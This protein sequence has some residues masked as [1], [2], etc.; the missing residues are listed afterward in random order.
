MNKRLVWNFE[1]STESPLQLPRANCI[2][3][4]KTHWESR[5]FWPDNERIVLRGLNDTHRE[6]S[7]YQVKHREDCYFLLPTTDYNIKIRHEQLSYKPVLMKKPC[8]IAYGKKIKLAEWPTNEPLPGCT[9]KNT[10]ALME[11]IQREGKKINVEKEALIYTFETTPPIKLELAWLHVAGNGYFSTSIE[12]RCMEYV[13]SMSRQLLGDVVTRD[14]VS[15]LK[16][17]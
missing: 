6:L 16:S 9:E 5:F 14:Y 3:E 4:N 13:E 7:R 11:R 12:S 1:I 8:A 15:F 17:T 2:D 10:A